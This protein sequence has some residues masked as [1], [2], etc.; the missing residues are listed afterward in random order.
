MAAADAPW[1]QLSKARRAAVYRAIGRAS[2]IAR[3]DRDAELAQDLRT[4]MNVLRAHAVAGARSRST[5]K[6]RTRSTK[7]RTKR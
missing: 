3:E 6:R 2:R 1:Q 7:K 5:T 4:I